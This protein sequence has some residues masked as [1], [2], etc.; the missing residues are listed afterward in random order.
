MHNFYFSIG[1][2][3]ED[4][5]QTSYSIYGPENI[6]SEFNISKNINDFEIDFKLKNQHA[7][8]PNIIDEALIKLIRQF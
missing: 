2:L 1:H 3:P 7:L 6:G 5:T 8:R 4:G